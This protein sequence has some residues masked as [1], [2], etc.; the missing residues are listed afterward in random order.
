LVLRV[1][2]FACRAFLVSSLPFLPTIKILFISIF[3]TFYQ[4]LS[5]NPTEAAAAVY[6]IA[7]EF[8]SLPR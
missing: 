5:L 3:I 8:C 4:S 6:P 7:F 1:I 2:G